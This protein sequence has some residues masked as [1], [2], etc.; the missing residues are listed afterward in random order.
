MSDLDGVPPVAAPT[1]REW[2]FNLSWR[3]E[4]SNPYHRGK[5]FV[6][7]DDEHVHVREVLPDSREFTRAELE[8]FVAKLFT[9]VSVSTMAAKQA[10]DEIF[11]VKP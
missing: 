1:R 8:D 11:G 6:N 10:L 9:K 4:H 3:G 5:R 2:W 7:D